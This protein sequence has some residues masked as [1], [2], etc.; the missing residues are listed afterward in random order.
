MR[1]NSGSPRNNFV[2]QRMKDPSLNFDN[3]RFHHFIAN[4]NTLS[5][6]NFFR[7]I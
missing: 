4:N 5:L 3:D 7:L 6:R 2:I 1:L